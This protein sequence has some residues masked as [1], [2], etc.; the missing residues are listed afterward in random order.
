MTAW[1]WTRAALAVFGKELR[2]EY[3]SRVAVLAV[4]LFA[5]CAL[6]LIALSLAGSAAT[7]ETASGLLWVLTLFTAATGLG[8]VFVAE[9]E[10]GTALALRLSA[11]GTAVWTGKFAA[12]ALLLLLLSGV[13]TPLLLMILAAKVAN[14]A[15]LFCVVMLGAIGTAATF[16]TMAA[17]VALSSARSGLLAALSFPLLVP[18]FVAAVH[19]TKAALGVGNEAG[20]FASGAGDVQVLA[21]YAVISVSTSLLLFDFVWTD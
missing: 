5:L 1:A 4:G 21:S 20:T 11:P 6:T 14:P 15:L 10:R 3:R 7:P 13:S 12:N 16:T 9:E 8:R 19:G 17:L 2:T 18:L